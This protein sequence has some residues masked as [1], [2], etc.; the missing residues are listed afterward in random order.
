LAFFRAAVDNTH[1]LARQLRSVQQSRAIG[2]RNMGSCEMSNICET[3]DRWLWRAQV[4]RMIA[5]AAR[6]VGTKRQML[7][8]AHSYE[9]CAEWAE[10]RSLRTKMGNSQS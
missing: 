2:W 8:I 10:R 1:V 9:R 5:D 3:R 7:G 4:A 6:E